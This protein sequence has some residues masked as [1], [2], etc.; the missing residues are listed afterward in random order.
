MPQLIPPFRQQPFREFDSLFQIRHLFG[1]LP[2]EPIQL[3]LM[4]RLEIDQPLFHTMHSLI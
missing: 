4:P 1:M 2:V 3:L